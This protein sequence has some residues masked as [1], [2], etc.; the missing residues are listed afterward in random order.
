A[1]L[2]AALV[3]P[4][5]RGGV[6]VVDLEHP[7]RR[8]LLLGEARFLRELEVVTTGSPARDELPCRGAE[9]LARERLGALGLLGLEEEDVMD[10][11]L[12][13]DLRREADDVTLLRKGDVDAEALI[14]VGRRSG[15]HRERLGR[16]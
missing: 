8:A 13:V 6:V 11:L 2:V 10:D 3:R 5:L 1:K 12:V 7:V 4:G 15:L 9:G 16:L 14:L